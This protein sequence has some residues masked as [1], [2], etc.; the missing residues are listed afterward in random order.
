MYNLWLPRYALLVAVSALILSIASA[1]L[2]PDTNS[3]RLVLAVVGVLSAILA[4][5]LSANRGVRPASRLS[6]LLICA[7]ILEGV[8]DEFCQA[9][10]KTAGI[11]HSCLVSAIVSLSAAIALLLSEF[12]ST[13]VVLLE[14]HG[15]PSLRSLS[16]F[17]AFSLAAQVGLGASY[18]R[19]AISIIPHIVGAMLVAAIILYLVMAVFM[20]CSSQREL[21]NP[22][23]LLTGLIGGQVLLGIVAFMNKLGAPVLALPPKFFSAAHIVT[24]SLTM[25]MTVILAMRIFR[26]ID[27]V[28]S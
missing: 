1:V 13:T 5:W 17:S 10:P 21:K 26:H 11:L 7:L 23:M 9:W 20:Q 12:R 16:V 28:N 15:A 19:E 3:Y 27:T 22:A 6:R 4:I 8:L 14:D 18:R 24:G 25:A 2:A